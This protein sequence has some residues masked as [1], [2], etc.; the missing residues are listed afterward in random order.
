MLALSTCKAEYIAL[1]NAVQEAKFLRQLCK[2]MK[3]SAGEDNVLIHID[4]QGAINLPR[5]PIHHQ[6]SKHIHIKYHFIRSEIQASIVSLEYVP[7]EETIAYK[8]N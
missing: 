8:A 3:V 7:T 4:N 1:A 2:D 6:R 5:N